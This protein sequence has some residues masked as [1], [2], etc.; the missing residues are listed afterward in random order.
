MWGRRHLVRRF[1]LKC[2]QYIKHQL[3]YI[4]CEIRQNDLRRLFFRNLTP[5]NSGQ[6]ASFEHFNIIVHK[7]HYFY[8][9]L[10]SNSVPKKIRYNT[11]STRYYSI[12]VGVIFVSMACGRFN[13]SRKQTAAILYPLKKTNVHAIRRSFKADMRT[14]HNVLSGSVVYSNHNTIWQY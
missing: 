13:S 7:N 2:S 1:F 14:R 5:F 12:R 6:H 3:S 9:L 10:Y 4:M 8:K 11:Q